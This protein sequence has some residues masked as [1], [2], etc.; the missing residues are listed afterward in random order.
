MILFM[1]SAPVLCRLFALPGII[2]LILLRPWHKNGAACS[3]SGLPA[4]FLS[5]LAEH[6][7]MFIH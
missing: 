4:C 3:L 6:Q 1:N 5:C 2:D 7:E